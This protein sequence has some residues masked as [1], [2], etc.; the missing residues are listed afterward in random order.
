MVFHQNEQNICIDIVFPSNFFTLPPPN[1]LPFLP[2]LPPPNL[3]EPPPGFLNT[4]FS[5]YSEINKFFKL[6]TKI[7]T[8]GS[9]IQFLQKCK[10]ENVFPSFIKIWSNSNSWMSN[11]V[12]LAA[13]RHWLNVELKSLYAK[14]SKLEIQLYDLHLKITKNLDKYEF[15]SFNEKI[16]NMLSVI[17]YK[18]NKKQ[19][20]QCKKLNQLICSQVKS[21]N[22]PNNK[23]NIVH[24]LSNETFSENEIK[25]L[26]Q[27][28]NFSLQ[29]SKLPLDNLIIDIEAAIKYL[30]DTDKDLIRNSCKLEILKFKNAK[31]YCSSLNTDWKTLKSLKSKNCYY[32]KSDKSNSIVIMDKNEYTNKT[33]AM[34][35]EGP[36]TILKKSPLNV[37]QTR[38]IESIKNCK[39]LINNKHLKW[40]LQISNPVLPKLYCLPKIHKTGIPMRPIVSGINSPSYWISKFLVH[41]FSQLEPPK[42]FSIKNSHDFIAKVKDSKLLN[43]EYMVSFDVNSLFPSIPIPESIKLLETWLKDNSISNLLIPEYLKLT[44][45]CMNQTAFQFNG[46]FY[47]QTFGTAMGN[48][49]SPF[50]ANLFMSH[51]ETELSAKCNYFP[52]I[53]YRY[54]DDIFAIVS[55]TKDRLAEF[56]E[57]MNSQYPSIKFTVEVEVD[58]KLPFLDILISRN[59]GILDFNVYRKPTQVDRFIDNNSFHPKEHKLAAFHSMV[60]RM[61]TFPLSKENLNAEV[62]YIKNVAISNGFSPSIIDNIIR[63]Q[64]FTLSIKSLTTIRKEN[65]QS[66]WAK[67][68]YFPPIT[69]N[70]KKIFAQ[71]N[72]KTAQYSSN[73]I[74]TIVGSTKDK[75]ELLQKSGIY[76]ITCQGCN[77]VYIGQTIRTIQK[78]FKEH[79][80]KFKNCHPDQSSV[81]KHLIDNCNSNLNHN[82]TEDNLFL[83]QE[84]NDYKK[85]DAF[86]SLFIIKEKSPLMNADLGP[87]QNT[88]LLNLT[89][90]T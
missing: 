46:K 72:L 18:N 6:K 23:M 9:D 66:K 90:L 70:I 31:K 78:R 68:L 11:K 15:I 45:L 10:T 22:I 35:S 29:P 17:K 36:Y 85:M 30:P 57:L 5:K 47:S 27:G 60:Y 14:R 87:I 20:A 21:S 75:T 69:N 24:N 40:K 65:E 89:S 84:V 43:N 19:M 80:S 12:I 76:K 39:N 53:F 41:E 74:K 26:N 48:P 38:C 34:L 16:S 2:I 79:I 71:H 32:I 86:E 8:I 73:K 13:K 55:F 63:K 81:A 82:I 88:S 61:L 1:I 28:L 33:E 54:V 42:G 51:F 59:N 7:T 67:L 62:S 52:R 4:Q 25:F 64:K 37:F 50:L 3:T 77:H 44:Q 49:L 58:S 83:L 56:T